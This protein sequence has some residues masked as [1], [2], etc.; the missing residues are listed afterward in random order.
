MCL[1]LDTLRGTPN[2]HKTA[3][4]FNKPFMTVHVIS[5]C[6]ITV[7]TDD[8]DH[9]YPLLSLPYSQRMSNSALAKAKTVFS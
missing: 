3:L 7:V 5:F 1:T 8:I 9:F 4:Q 6:T 2:D